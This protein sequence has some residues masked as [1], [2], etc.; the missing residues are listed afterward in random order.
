MS[1]EFNRNNGFLQGAANL[2]WSY[3]AVLTPFQA[4]GVA[5]RALP[6]AV[7]AVA[8]APLTR[9]AASHPHAHYRIVKRL[10]GALPTHLVKCRFLRGPNHLKATPPH[11]PPVGAF[12][13]LAS[14]RILRGGAEMSQSSGSVSR[15]H[16]CHRL[17]R[18]HDWQNR[19]EFDRLCDWW[20]AGGQGV[21]PL[22]GIGGAGKTAIVERFL[23]VTPGLTEAS[24]NLAKDP[25]LRPPNRLFV[26]SFYDAPN[27]DDFFGELGAWLTGWSSSAAGAASPNAAARTTGFYEILAILQSSAD[28]LL[29]LDGLEKVQDDI[30]RE[31]VFGRPSMR[32]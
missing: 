16:I 25:S 12:A 6:P 17:L 4:R 27:P 31:S 10:R 5:K 30:A 13:I 28:C 21:L 22:S 26:Y 20:R 29:V 15:Y 11:L 2:T 23:C 7:S 18:A 1:E 8:C 3:A 19:P 14:E 9:V 24:T 32:T